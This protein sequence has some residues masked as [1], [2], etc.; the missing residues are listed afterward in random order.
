MYKDSEGNM[1][2]DESERAVIETPGAIYDYLD[3]I[4]DELDTNPW[5]PSE[6]WEDQYDNDNTL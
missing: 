6:A 4:L 3:S 1:Q 5:G 2:L